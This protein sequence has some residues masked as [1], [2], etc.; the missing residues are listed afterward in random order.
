MDEK[1]KKNKP[2]GKELKYQKWTKEQDNALLKHRREGMNLS[3][4][5]E[6]FFP[7]RQYDAVAHRLKNI[8]PRDERLKI[9]NQKYAITEHGDVPDIKEQSK[10]VGNNG[11]YTTTWTQQELNLLQQ[12]INEKLSNNQ[13]VAKY[14][15]HR[16]FQA[17]K[18]KRIDL[19]SGSV[20]VINK[21][22]NARDKYI[23]QSV[24]K[25][26]QNQQDKI[27][28]KWALLEGAIKE[29][30]YK[31]KDVPCLVGKYNKDAKKTTEVPVLMLSDLHIGEKHEGI[32]EEYNKQIFQ[33]RMAYLTSKV[34]HI[35]KDILS[36]AYNLPELKI[37][38]GGDIITNE[39]L[40]P[41]QPFEID[42]SITEQV[43]EG[44]KIVAENINRLSQYF[45]KIEIF[46]VSGNHSRVTKFSNPTTSW[47]YFFYK[48]VES[49]LQNNPRVKF[50]IELKDFKQII[51]I[52]GHQFM[53]TH[54]DRIRAFQGIPLYGIIR[55]VSNWVSMFIEQYP[56]L[57]YFCFG[58]FHV[59]SI[60]N[61]NRRKI[62]MNGT[63]NSGGQF[64]SKEMKSF[65]SISQLFWGVSKSR[66][67]TWHY[68]LDLEK[69]K[70]VKGK[71]DY[72]DI[73]E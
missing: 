60:L 68:E 64:A 54:G 36:K 44:A 27:E 49:A 55:A 20:A 71:A 14:L 33:N 41:S 31:V 15:P 26:K 8:M 12:G 16:T 18:S 1:K 72:L 51:E 32:G 11:G 70:E 73:I 45:Q 30:M 2:Q 28:E 66:G 25:M 39:I 42:M 35:S 23:Q 24:A 50:N 58:H 40:F 21:E 10:F 56:R 43:F 52:E 53:L 59:S 22:L 7:T 17:V 19:R 3:D 57:K 13:I 47:D 61:W 38:M 37:F 34:I 29:C 62:L 4:I 48:A 9:N 67:I 46:A 65:P 5:Q 63:F 6:K 69:I